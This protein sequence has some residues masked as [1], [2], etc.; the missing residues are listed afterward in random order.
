MINFLLAPVNCKAVPGENA[1][2][3]DFSFTGTKAENGQGNIT[4]YAIKISETPINN[5]QDFLMAKNGFSNYTP[6]IQYQEQKV[7][8]SGLEP[9]KKYY[10]AVS[11]EE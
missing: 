5:K 3:L 10:L 2:E 9:N 8:L 6:L 1:G 4:D 11:S 7:T